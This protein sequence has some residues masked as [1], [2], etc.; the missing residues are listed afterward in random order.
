MKIAVAGT[1]NR[2]IMTFADGKQVESPG[3][4]IYS[5]LTLS[6]LAPENYTIIPIA[7]IGND[8]YRQVIDI[9]SEKS[10]ISVSGIK[11]SD[12]LN[13]T[14]YLQLNPDQERIEHTDIHL[15]PLQFLQFSPFME[16]DVLVLNLTSGFELESSTLREIVKAFKG[17]LY[18][19]MHSLTLGIDE[20]RKRFRLKIPEPGN[21]FEGIDFVQ[22]TSGEAWSFHDRIADSP[23][24]SAQTGRKI[25]SLV[26]NAC[27][28]TDGDNGV[29]I[30]TPDGEKHIP[31]VKVDHAVDTTGCGDVFGAS[32]LIEYLKS[33][34]LNKSVE[35]GVHNAGIK[36][37]FAGFTGIDNLLT[38]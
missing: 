25:A 26:K 3:G 19:D 13:N 31:A 10:N 18:L 17:I 30:F 16:A 27:L 37:S 12:T 6:A 32:F 5:I 24:L 34:D 33:G 15:P 7:N 8:I 4:L 21:W 23:E 11:K 2:D 29:T 36:C 22:L 28:M 20:N 35:Y 38:D 1:V 14:V 9:L